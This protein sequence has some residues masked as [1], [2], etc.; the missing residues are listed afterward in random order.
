MSD[1]EKTF[2]EN[3]QKETEFVIAA[4]T[5]KIQPLVIGPPTKDMLDNRRNVPTGQYVPKVS[6]QDAFQAR[7]ATLPSRTHEGASASCTHQG[8]SASGTPQG[9][10]ASGTHQGASA[11]GTPQDASALGSLFPLEDRAVVDKVALTL[12]KCQGHP[13]A[14]FLDDDVMSTMSD[15]QVLDLLKDKGNEEVV[16]RSIIL[17]I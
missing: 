9:A 16:S 10:S 13:S 12:I 8:E 15:R 4:I 1:W 3:W 2:Q 6:L 11:S 17:T 14:D 7:G 5:S